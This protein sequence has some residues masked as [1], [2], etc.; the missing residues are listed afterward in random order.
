MTHDGRGLVVG[1]LSHVEVIRLRLKDKSLADIAKIAGVTPERVRAALALHGYTSRSPEIV[2]LRVARAKMRN[3]AHT[4]RRTQEREVKEALRLREM[5]KWSKLWKSNHSIPELVTI[6]GLSHGTVTGKIFQY[7]LLNK[8]MFPPRRLI[9]D[10]K[11]IPKGLQKLWA[12]NKTIEDIAHKYSTSTKQVERWLLVARRKQGLSAFPHHSQLRDAYSPQSAESP[13]HY[14]ER[15]RQLLAPLRPEWSAGVPIDRLAP[16]LG[17]SRTRL[18]SLLIVARKLLGWFPLRNSEQ[19]KQELA[20]HLHKELEPAIK[21]WKAGVS[22]PQMATTLGME[23]KD[24]VVKIK[25]ARELL[26][27]DKFPRRQLTGAEYNQKRLLMSRLWKRGLPTGEIAAKLGHKERVVHCVIY[28][29]RRQYGCDLFPMRNRKL[30][31]QRKE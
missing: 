4:A 13:E 26:G 6:F 27:N 22:I 21:L 9:Y 23:Y 24:L 31:P 29:H 15:L 25:R 16:R 18:Y 30:G 7:R 14:R 11:P 10:R 20:R 5:Q 1:H 17:L 2:A 8:E 3:D 28:K 19:R 12:Q